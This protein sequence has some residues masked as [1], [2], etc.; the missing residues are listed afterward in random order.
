MRRAV[1]ELGAGVL[2]VDD[3]AVKARSDLH[4]GHANIIGFQD[5]PFHNVHEMVGTFWPNWQLCVDPEDTV[6]V[7]GD[8][9]LGEAV[10]EETWDRVREARG[11]S[12]VVVVGNH[13]IT[14]HGF[15]RVKVF[16]RAKAMLISPGDPPLIWT[17]LPLLNVP[18]GHVNIHGHQHTHLQPPDS[19]HINVSVEQLDYRPVGLA[20]LRRLA[21][22]LV[23]GESLAGTTTL[24][25]IEAVEGLRSCPCR[26]R[27]A[28]ARAPSGNALACSPAS[29]GH[30]DAPTLGSRRVKHAFG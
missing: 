19:P 8:F 24:E 23:A 2:D 14:G 26:F 27:E 16:H 7:V 29:Q 30:H 12:K 5:R 4:L 25:R 6:V 15:L 20:R 1:N 18:A 3:E 17:H 9:A 10:S 21:Q 11:R 22:A 28:R 13:D